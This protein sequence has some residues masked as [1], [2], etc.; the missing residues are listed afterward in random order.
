MAQSQKTGAF[1]HMKADWKNRLEI[2]GQVGKTRNP[3]VPTKEMIEAGIE[4]FNN[5]EIQ[6]AS[7][8]VEEIWRA[9]KIVE[10]NNAKDS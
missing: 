6:D 10:L 5:L 9:M 3:T 7:M 4:V 1:N 8:I 2:T